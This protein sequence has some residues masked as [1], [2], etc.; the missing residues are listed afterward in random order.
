[1]ATSGRQLE[2]ISKLIEN[3]YA[4][5]ISKLNE[6]ECVD[7]KKIKAVTKNYSEFNARISDWLNT[8]SSLPVC[9]N[10]KD[11]APTVISNTSSF[12]A[13]SRST[14]RQRETFAK[15]KLAELE[16]AQAEERAVEN[17][18]RAKR[19]ARRKLEIAALEFKV[20]NTVDTE[21]QSPR[22]DKLNK[23]V[24]FG[25]LHE[26]VSG[27]LS[28]C[29]PKATLS[30]VVA[31][32]AVASNTPM[33]TTETK[34]QNAI[35]SQGANNAKLANPTSSI[36]NIYSGPAPPAAPLRSNE[37]GNSK[38]PPPKTVSITNDGNNLNSWLNVSAS[39]FVP[40]FSNA[41]SNFASPPHLNA[42]LSSSSSLSRPVSSTPKSPQHLPTW[43]G[44]P[45]IGTF[46]HPGSYEQLAQPIG[47]SP[48]F[49]QY[50]PVQNLYRDEFL[51]PRPQIPKF[52][53]NPLNFMTFKNNFVKHI[54]PKVADRKML[55]CYLLQHCE[56]KIR[57]KIQHFSNKGEDGYS[58][59][60]DRLEK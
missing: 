55:L 14:I 54:V 45:G 51:L 9:D 13:S 52:D 16:A 8:L 37:R 53:G 44:P 24:N 17:A 46:P 34:F 39:G 48:Y 22:Y 30:S 33:M 2:E 35:S 60:S 19:E 7:V 20:W 15:L 25:I 49:P 23:H 3:L 38:L 59:A 12:S 11:A 27:P 32:L 28:L 50:Q 57:D 5:V 4:Q 18:E 26:N 47:Y 58:L 42:V 1:M 41:Q 29:N 6:E 40:S 56:P 31:D 36:N 43:T 21:I 10:P